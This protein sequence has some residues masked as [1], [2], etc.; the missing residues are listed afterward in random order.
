MAAVHPIDLA[1]LYRAHLDHLLAGLRRA[2]SPPAGLDALVIGS[3]PLRCQE[4][5]FD[6]Q[7]FPFRPTPGVRPLAAAG[8]AECALVIAARR[9]APPGPRAA[10]ELL[11]RADAG[12]VRSLLVRRST[13]PRSRPTRS[14]ARRCR[15]GGSPSSATSP[16]RPRRGASPPRR[17]QPAGAGRR[18]RR[19]ARAQDRVRAPLP[20]RGQPPRGRRPPRAPSSAF[21][22]R[23][24][25]ASSSST[26][27]TSTP[28]A[29]TTPRRPYKNI[30][31]LGA[32]AAVL[33]HVALRPRARRAA[34]TSLLID[35]GATYLGYGSDITRTAVRGG[36]AAAQLFA[37]A[38]RAAS[39]RCSRRS[40]GAIR[41]GLPYEAL[42]D[43]AHELL[44]PVLRELGLIDASR[45]RAGRQRRDA[46]SSC[47]T[48]SATRSASRS[49]TSAA[50]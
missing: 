2:R 36:G 49:T 11:G 7:D 39:R 13:S 35:A 16:R 22:E 10:A 34:T 26:S 23:R 18:A 8:R 21:R 38:G 45:R 50:G 24:R 6:D 40:A 29:R 44:A 30:V 17:G 47:R 14:R 27:R 46:A 42:H 28:P 3:G 33:H 9:A 5:P 20:R 43:H 4:S 31:A 37:R 15:A 32:H 1:A 12:R 41:P 48:A 19:D 25:R